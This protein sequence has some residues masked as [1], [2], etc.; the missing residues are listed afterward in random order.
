MIDFSAVDLGAIGGI[1]AIFCRVGCCFMLLPGISSAR[2]PGTVRLFLAL[3][4]SLALWPLLAGA[5]VPVQAIGLDL[6]S[7]G[8]I[9]AECAAGVAIGLAARFFLAALHMAGAL[10][11]Q[12]SGYGH[13]Y[14][15]DDGHG[16]MTSELGALMSGAVIALL[17]VLDLHHMALEALADS[18]SVVR[19]GQGLAPLPEM[20]RLTQ[21]AGDSLRLAVGLSAPFIATSILVNLAFG[22]LNR[23]APQV[24]VVFISSAFLLAAMFWLSGPLMPEMA[25][26]GAQA[27][28]FSSFR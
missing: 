19:F 22:M 23:M 27:I 17:L 28:L 3:G 7:L 18:Y 25:R 9:A 16:E 5:S 21:A 15:A 8:V 13:A 2:L 11:A 4:I 6:S 24:P 20:H 1:F 26:L 14:L 10:I 12:V